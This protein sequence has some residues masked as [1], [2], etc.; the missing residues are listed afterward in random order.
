VRRIEHPI[1]D[2]ANLSGGDVAIGARQRRRTLLRL[3]ELA[4]AETFSNSLE[5]EVDG[6]LMG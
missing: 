6:N 3:L 4:D 5:G 1:F 2:A